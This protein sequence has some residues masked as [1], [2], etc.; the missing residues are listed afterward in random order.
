MR[1]PGAA[2]RPWRE[3]PNPGA[4]PREPEASRLRDTVRRTGRRTTSG[5]SGVRSRRLRLTP[6]L[7]AA[8]ESAGSGPAV[9]PGRRGGPRRDGP[10]GR[11]AVQAPPRSRAQLAHRMN[12]G[13]S[14]LRGRRGEGSA[15][16]GVRIGG[17]RVGRAG[18]SS[19]DREEKE[20]ASCLKLPLIQIAVAFGGL[21]QVWRIVNLRG[22]PAYGQLFS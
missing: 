17:H 11:C 20:S 2:P 7:A 12:E 3:H 22:S 4:R 21:F 14:A 9:S 18:S 10:A 15:V 16:V 1:L 19:R 13:A 8:E 6:Q 5:D